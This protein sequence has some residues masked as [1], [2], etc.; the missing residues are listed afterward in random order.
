M[1]KINIKTGE[2]SRVIDAAYKFQ[3][4]G[5][6]LYYS[7][8]KEVRRKSLKDGTETS[9]YNF[10]GSATGCVTDFAVLN[11][12]LYLADRNHFFIL[13][14][15]LDEESSSGEVRYTL[16][17]YDMALRGDEGKQYLIC[18]ISKNDLEKGTGSPWMRVYDEDGRMIMEREGDI[19][20]DSVSIEGDKICYYNNTTNQINVEKL[21]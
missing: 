12:N 8:G 13:A 15:G 21:R 4:E 1:Y 17:C 19:R 6:Y 3:I 5:D 20:L 9:L 7:T 11:G 2:T 16:A 18:D 14:S 10:F